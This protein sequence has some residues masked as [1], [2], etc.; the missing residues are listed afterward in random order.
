MSLLFD[1]NI[2]PKILKIL[3]LQFSG[4]SQ[5]RFEGLENSSDL[6]IFHYAK[7]KHF[8]IVS[9]DSDFI[10]L[11]GIYGTPPKIIYLNTGNLITK[12]ISDLLIKNSLRISHYIDSDSDEIL[13]LIQAR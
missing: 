9:F 7:K 5:V 4:S 10:D 6:E 11:N 1:Q 8:T 12:N 13:E 3:P 2:S